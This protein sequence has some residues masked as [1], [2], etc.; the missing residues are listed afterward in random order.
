MQHFFDQFVRFVQQ[1]I[2]ALFRFIQLIWAWSVDQITALLQVP[3]QEWPPLKQVLLVAVIGVVAWVLYYAAKE[4]WDAGEKILAAFGIVVTVL[5]KTL[6]KVLLAGLIA[7]GGVWLLNH[8]DLSRL[9]LPIRLDTG[10]GGDK[11]SDE[12]NGSSNDKDTDAR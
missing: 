3:W 11:R 4:L 12:D 7:L 5:V 2:A 9:Q 8:I 1:G 6:P 10:S